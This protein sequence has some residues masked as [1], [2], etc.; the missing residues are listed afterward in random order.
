LPAATH[1]LL[2]LALLYVPPART[3]MADGGTERSPPT[4]PRRHDEAHCQLQVT[5]PCLR[6]CDLGSSTVGHGDAREQ[7]RG[8]APPPSPALVRAPSHWPEPHTIRAGGRERGSAA[9]RCVMRHCHAHT[10]S[11]TTC[12]CLR[13]GYRLGA[14]CEGSGRPRVPPMPGCAARE[15][16]PPWRHRRV[17]DLQEEGRWG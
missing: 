9:P 12:C 10:R 15:G 13:R 5:G 6:L 1:P 8:Q 14:P 7:G 17:Q 11:S 16:G 3:S 2:E 4:R